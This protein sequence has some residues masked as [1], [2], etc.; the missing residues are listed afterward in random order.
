MAD[1]RYLTGGVKT[2]STG[3]H[4]RHIVS[5]RQNH[6]IF[7]DTAGHG[8]PGEAVNALELFLAGITGCATMMVER[9][10]KAEKLPLKR[11]EVTMDATIDTEAKH[12]GPPVLA[13]ARM[14]FKIEGLPE[15]KAREMVE[16]YKHR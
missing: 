4:G 16:T 2:Y 6:F 12:E 10:A 14:L 15:A 3:I 11:V 9:L 5:A 8:G 1:E 13:D 7:D